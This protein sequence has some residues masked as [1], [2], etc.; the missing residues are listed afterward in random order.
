MT[1][2]MVVALYVV[3]MIAVIVSADLLCFRNRLWER[4]MWNIGI[5]VML[6][7]IYL[8]FMHSP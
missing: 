1:R 3:V 2:N 8:G 5:V 7:A 4:L 6:A